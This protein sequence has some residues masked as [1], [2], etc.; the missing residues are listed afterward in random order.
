MLW[1]R[2]ISC[3]SPSTYPA[4]SSAGQPNP[5]ARQ[6]YP[7]QGQVQGGYAGAPPYGAPAY[8]APGYGTPTY[9]APQ[10]LSGST[11]ALLVVSGLTTLGCGFGIVALI[12]AIIA[13]AKKDQPADSAKYTRWGWIAFGVGLLLSV[14][15]IGVVIAGLAVS[16]GTSTYD[17]GY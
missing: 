11:I 7:T 6:Q 1:S 13:A 8:G 15:V 3:A 9:A 4:K 14:I 16:G 5:Y 10:S 2:A 17:S 12:F